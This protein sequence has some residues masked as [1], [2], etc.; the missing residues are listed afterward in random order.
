MSAATALTRPPRLRPGARIAVV[1]PSGPVVE[2]RLWA[3]LDVLRGW[4]LDPVATS[5]VTEREPEFRYLAGDDEKRARDF[6][7]AWCDPRVEAVMCARGG[8]GAQR[9]IDL[10]DWDALRAA[11]P[12][13][14]IGY[15]DATVLHE[16][17]AARLGLSTLY[18]PMASTLSF[19][20]DTA[21][22]ESLRTTLFEPEAALTLG[23]PGAGALVPGRA[24]GVTFGGCLSL[25]AA[26]LATPGA[27]PPAE[28]GLLLLEDI[29]EQDYRLDRTL[30]QLLRAGRLEGVTGIALGSWRECGPYEER[31]RPVLRERLGRLGVPIAE[32]VG[33]GHRDNALTMPLG[34]TAVLDADRGTLTLEAPALA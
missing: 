2:Q 34:V 33:F 7:D 11:G 4:G 24:R 17:F 28:G 32:N 10:L 12:K 15:S 6:Q 19:L 5:Q 21:T 23:L 30:T 22:Q 31:V 3:G 20:T 1:A 14:F 29:G 8:Y 9:M 25:L 27:R 16:A 13:V 18:G 26:D